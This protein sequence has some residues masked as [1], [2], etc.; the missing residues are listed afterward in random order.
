MSSLYDPAY[1]IQHKCDD[2]TVI[3]VEV[4]RV[5]YAPEHKWEARPLG[6]GGYGCRGW[7]RTRRDAVAIA[8]EKNR[9]MREAQA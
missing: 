4:Q 5:N 9:A 7:A 6:E 3:A 1:T 8:V 2:G